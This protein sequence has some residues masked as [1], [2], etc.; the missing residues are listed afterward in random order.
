[1]S[2]CFPI[3]I[4]NLICRAGSIEPVEES[5]GEGGRARGVETFPTVCAGCGQWTGGLEKDLL[6]CGRGGEHGKD[7]LDEIF[8]DEQGSLHWWW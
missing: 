1:M 5:S 4:F 3:F 8:S 6:D 2:E 7:I